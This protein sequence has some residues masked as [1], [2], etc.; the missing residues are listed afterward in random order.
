MSH[1]IRV[2]ARAIV[3]HENAVLL[4][5][6]DNGLYY[7]FPGGGIEESETAKQAVV[8]EVLEETGLT[9][10]AG[11]L[12][13]ALEYEPKSCRGIYGGRAHISFFFRCDWNRSVSPQ[14]I[15]EPDRN[16]ENPSVTSA[17]KWV[18]LADLP[19]INLVPNI[20]KPLLD[21]SVTGSFTPSFWEECDHIES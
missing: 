18:K 20:A 5:E 8:R 6:F 3:L 12:V 9:V 16:P 13:F 4:N 1:T 21:Y 2:S 10:D 19:A 11:D 14:G 15:T 17:V 7:N